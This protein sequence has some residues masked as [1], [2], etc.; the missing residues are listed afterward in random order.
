MKI[1]QIHTDLKSGGIEA[2]VV[3]LCNEMINR[4]E[5]SFCT[6]FEPNVNDVFFSCLDK[7]IPVYTAHKKTPGGNIKYLWRV[8]RIIAKGKY[9]IVNMHGC[10]YYY[11]LA[12]FLLHKK[13]KFFYTFHSEAQKENVGWDIKLFYLKYWLLKK[14]WIYPITISLKT[15]ISFEE[16]Y[17]LPSKM[18]YNGTPKPDVQYFSMDQYRIT[19]NTKIL[20][21]PGRITEAKNQHMLCKVCNRLQQEGY[22]IVLLLAGDN[23]DQNIYSDISRYFSLRIRYLGERNDIVN[24]L[25]KSDAL[26][27]SSIWEGLPMVLLEALSV[28]CIPVCTPVGGIPEVIS[29]GENGFLS[30]SIE[31]DDYYC[32]LREF[33]DSDYNTIKRMKEKCLNTFSNFNIQN[34]ALKYEEYYAEILNI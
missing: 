14:R 12:V 18:I 9:D 1:L 3:G 13:I 21:H 26:C 24:I 16:L 22:D 29:N 2:V 11:L 23:Q 8:Y 10:L 19:S 15:Q 34:I 28:G 30:K 32:A 6:I 27:L 7:R 33:L 31:E 25:N 4:H 20:F 5:L 17:G